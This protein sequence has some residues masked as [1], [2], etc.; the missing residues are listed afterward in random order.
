M[1][2][3]MSNK[4]RKMA[5]LTALIG[6]LMAGSS[7]G[8]ANLMATIPSDYANSQMGGVTGSRVTTKVDAAPVVG[9]VKNLNRDPATFSVMLDGESKIFLRQYVYGVTDLKGSILMD[10]DGD[11]A[12]GANPTGVIKAVPNAHAV[13][14]FGNTIYATGYDQGQVGIAHIVDNQIAEDT[15]KTVDLKKDIKEKTGDIDAKAYDTY[16]DTNGSIQTTTVHG[17]GLLV[18]DGYLYV[19][20]SVNLKGGYDNYDNGYLMQYKINSDGGL[21]YNGYARIGK[22]TDQV[23]LN[24]YNHLIL[25]TSI[26]GYQNYGFGN[27][28][29]SLDYV[30]INGNNIGNL[31]DK[32]S[33]ILPE[34]V[35]NDGYDFRDMKVLPDGTVYVMKYTLS[36]VGGDNK[37][38]FTGRVYQTTMANLMS[39]N[40]DDWNIVLAGTVGE[41][42]GWFGRL[43]AEY[44]T[45][46]L[47]VEWGN[48]LYVY[49][50]GDTKPTHQWETKDFSTD[51]QFYQFNS[52]T[53]LPTDQ[54][55]GSL[56]KLT[57]YRPEGFT[58]SSE[59]KIT[60]EN[61]D[62][63]IG[64]VTRKAGIT[65]TSADQT[66]FSDVI[67]DDGTYSF[68]KDEVL[69]INLGKEGDHAT[70]AAAV[71]QAK[72]GKDITI[73]AS[74]HTLQLASKNYI[75]SPVG[76]YA[77]NGKNVTITADKVDVVTSGYS[78]GNSLT[79]AI[80]NDGGKNTASQ[81]TVNGD[82]NISMSDG[83]GGNGVAI[84]K[85]FRWGENSQESKAS[86]A[87]T[88]HGNLKIAGEDSATWGIPVN[89]E[90][91][92]SRFNNAGILTNIE[93]SKVT[94]TGD[95]DMAV[96]GNGITTN[97]VGSEV[98]IGGGH[99]TVPQGTK[100]G[101]YTLGAYAGTINVNMNKAGSAAG[102]HDVQLD[103]DVFALKSTGTIN[104][105]LATKNSYLHGII[106]NGGKVNMWLQNGAVWT[107][108]AKNTRYKQDDEDV[109]NNEVSRVTYLHGG[110][111][112]GTGDTAGVIIQTANSKSLTIDKFSG[113]AKVL[114]SHDSTTPTKILGGDVNIGSAIRGSEIVLRT[115]YDDN[116]QSDAVKNQVLNALAEK[117]YYKNAVNG[118]TFLS[119]KV[120][121]AEGLT[122]SSV[123][124][125]TG[126]IAFNQTNGQGSFA[127]SGETPEPPAEQ[128]K[129]LF[130]SSMTGGDDKE[131]KDDHVWQDQVYTFTKDKTTVQVEGGAAVDAVK[132][133][134]ITADGNELDL[135]GGE[136]G[137][138]AAAGKTVDITAGT[139]K[140]N[141]RTGIDA[142]GTV[143]LKGKSEITG[144]EKAVN[145]QKG[146]SV[147]LGTSTISGDVENSGHLTLDA[148]TTVSG[149]IANAGVLAVNGETH[150][151]DL[152]TTGTMTVGTDG[153]LAADNINVNGGTFTANGSVSSTVKADKGGKAIL[154]GK[155]TVLK[156]LVSGDHSNIE[157]TLSG[158]DSAL[159]GS[160]D[161]AGSVTLSLADQA[162]WT[163]NA[164]GNGAYAVTVGKDSTWTG[165]SAGNNTS[166]TLGG[167]WNN[168]GTSSLK[169]M[170]GNGGVIDMTD[171]KAGTVTIQNYGGSSTYI[172]KH[173]TTKPADANSGYAILGGDVKISHAD[174]GS[175]I[176]LLTDRT[177]LDF[178]S[179][180]ADGKNLISGTLNALAGKLYY[181][182]YADGNLSGTVKIAEGLTASSASLRSETI[183]FSTADTG[184]KKAGQ[185][186]YDYTP[187]TDEKPHETGPIVKSE[188]ID[189]TR[190]GDV[191]GIVSINVTEAQDSVAS[192]APSAMY[193]AGDAVSPLVVDLQGHTLKLNANNQTANY[194]STVYVDD[195]KSMEIKDSKGNGVLKV[196]AGLDADGNTDTKAKY[197]Y[198][199]RV[200]EGGSLTADT[201]VEIDGVKSNS[202]SRAFGVYAYSE[203][204]V[205]F[206][207]DLT[208]KNVQ[209]ANKVGPYTA[210]I[211][212]DASS[213]AKSPINITVK[214]NL[215]IENV[216]GS[217]IRALNTST[218]STAGATIKAADMS[219]GTDKSQ[220]YA[221]QAN[222]GTINLNTGEGIT[223]GVLDVTGDMKVTDNK[224]SVIN[225]NMT[226]GS[227][228]TGAVSN[229]SSSTYNAPAGQFNLT[230]AEGSAWKHETGRSADTL[231]TTFAGS[232]VSKL[233][234]S[235]VIYQNSDKGITVY[236]YS[237]DTT[238]V[239]GHD[240]S[241]PLII[242]GGD[243]TIKAAA[244][245]SKITLVTDSQGIT[246]GFEAS[247]TAAEKN[248]VKEVLNKLA[249]KLFYT[250]YKDATLFGVVKIADGLT[251]SSVKASGDV[252]FSDGTNGTKKKGQ[253]FYAYTPEQEKPN[254][255]TG[256]ITKSEDISL[257][258]ELDESG[259]AHVSVTESNA[260]GDKFASALYAGESTSPSS[261]M[262]VKMSG[263]GL[264]LNVAQSSGQAAAI[265]AG[266]NTYIKVVNPS[267]DQKLAIT[268]NNTDT[269]GAHGIY[270]DGN[271]HLNISGPVEITDIV[272]KG[273]AATGI[274]IQGKQSEITIDGPL[275]IS[276]VKGL[277]ERGAGMNASGIQVT[278]DSST[279]T[280]SG[281]V[282][283]SGVRGSGIKLAGKDTKV[284]V[285]GGT[286][287]AAEDSDHSHNFY[288][289]RVDK[290]TLDIN[291]KDGAA[292]DTTTKIT[293][294][295]YATG[296]YGKKVVEYTGGELIDWKDAGILNVA[297]TDKDSFW[298]GV[299]AYDQYND[300]YGT[301]GN[302]AHDIGQFN[303]YL[304]NGATWTNE[305]Q[306]HVTTT[307]IASK[308]P[309]W[310]GST[311]ATLHGGKDADHAGL[312]YQKDNNPIS[313]VN[314]SG[315][316]TVFYEHD[317]ADPTKII[318]GNF[319][320]TNAAEGSAIT[321]IT[322]N[323]GIT[324][325]FAD[326]DSA[327][328][329]DKVANVLNNLAGKLFY[330]N[331]TD[332]HLSGVVKIA[333]G[334]TASSRALKTGD[335]S[336]STDATGTKTPGQ[337]Y[338]EYKTSKPGSQT[339]KEFTAAIT[340]D[341]SVDTAYADKGVL[342]D[343]GTYVFTA[344]S[345]TIT[346]E[347]HLI[348]GGPWLPQIS[349]AISGS[350]EKH[351]VTMDMNGN[352]L[353][354]DT[355]TDTHTTGIAAIGKGVV[356]IK[357][358]GAMSVS[359]TSTK[360]GQIGALFVNGGGTIQI[361]NAG[362]DNVLTLRAKST[363]PANAAVIKSMNGVSG[364]M[365]SI[366]VDGLVDILA[367]K[368]GGSGANEAISAV[369]SKVEVGG[370]V[371]KA[372]NG[373]EYAIRAYGEFNSKNRGQVN[374]NVK[375]DAKGAVIGAGSNTVQLEG[376]VYLG[377][378]M[379]NAGASAD[380]SLGLNTKDSF[381][382]GDV[383][384]ANGSNA[385]IVNLYMGSGASWTGN[386]LSGNT[387]NADLDNATWTGYSSGNA[388]H[389][390]LDNSIW[391]VNGASKIA[392]FSGNKGS[393]FV[394]SDAGNISVGDYSGNT[395]VIYNH[396]ADHPTN[397]LGGNF[398]IGQA[399]TGSHITLITDNQGITKGFTAQDKAEDQ[400]TVNEVL[401]KLAQKLFYTANDGKLA[402]TVKIAE[403]LTAS[404]KALK[405]G[406]ISFSTDATGTKTPGQGFYEYTA[407]DDS[408]ITDPIT[409][410]LD[411]KY[412]NLGIETEKGIY[413]FTQDTV[414]DV[415]KGDYSS[416]LSAIESSGGPITINA[417]GKNLDV[418]YHVLKGSNVARAVATGLRT[419]IKDVTI[420]AKSL[421]LSTD[422][423][424]FRAQGVYAT[425]GKI[426]IDADTT[427]ST[428]AQTESN[429]IYSGNGGTV[430]MS[431]NLTIQKDSKAANYIALKSDDN[432]VINVN[433]K[434]GKVGAGIVKI[435]GDVY[436]KS[437]ETYD[438]WEDETTSTSS[439]VNLALQGKDS[440]WNGRSLYEVTSGDDST[441]YGTFNLWL[442]DGATWTNEK[443]G[444][445]VPSGFT[446]SHVTK[447]TG[448][449]DAAHAGNIFQNDTKKITIDNYSGNTNIYYAHTGNG[450]AASDYA[451]G[452]T[453]IK[454]AEKDS[455]V[456]LITDN[457]G[458]NMNSADS[459]VNVLNSLAGKL[460]YSNFTKNENNLTGYVKIADG[461][462]SSSA[463][464]YTGDM[465]FSKKDGKGSLK[466]ED[467]IRPDLPAPDH[468]IKNEF[469]TT[470]TGVKSKDKEYYKA[471]VI[472][473]EGLYQ[474]TQNSSITT[475]N[476]HG[477]DMNQATTIDAKGKTLTFN[478]DLTYG[479]TVHAIGAN[480]TDGVTINAGKLVL[481][482]HSTNGRIEGINVGQGALTIN[483]NTEMNIKGVGYT[484]GLYAAGDSALTFNG[485][486]TAMGDETS[487]WGLT[488]KN[489][490]WGYY[491]CS[492]VYSD[493]NYG[494]QKGPKVTINGDVNAKIDG[495][496]LFAKGGHAKLTINGGGNIEINKDNEHTYYAMIAECGTTSM[497]VNLDENYDAVS[498]RDNKLV[499]KG[500]ISASTG[501]ISAHETE[502]YTKVNLGLATADSVW[503]GVAHNRF[504]DDGNSAYSSDKKFYGAINVFLQNGATWN[505]EKW[506]A[507]YKPWGSSGFAGSHVA[508][509]VGGSDVAHAGNIFQKDA[510]SLT[511]DNYSGNT[512]IFYAHTGNGEAADNYAAGDTVIKHAAEGSVVS[513]ITDNTGVAMDNEYSVAN[514]LNALAGKL[515]YSNFVTGE[516]NLTG[517]VKIAEGLTASSAAMQTGN[518]A[519]NA[520]TGK[521]SLENGS[522]KPGFTYPE[523]QKPEAT[524]KNQGITGDAKTD[525]QYKKDGILKEDGSY[526]F[527][528]NPTKIEV[529]SGAAV[530]ATENNINIDS[531]QAKLELKG[532]T[533]I[534]AN[535]ADVTVNGNTSISGKVGID[536]ANGNVTL[537]GS[538]DIVGTDA[539]INAGEGGNVDINTNNSA[540]N[541]KGDINADGGSIIVA[542]GKATGVIAGDVSASNG[543]SVEISLNDAKSSL[544]GSYR[545]DDSSSIV[546][547]I[548]NGAT[549]N[550]TDDEDDAEGMSLFRMAKAPAAAPAAGLNV[551]GGAT[552]AETGYIDMTK[553]TQKLDIANFSGWETIIYGHEN[554]GDKDE[555][556]KSGNT[557]INKAAKDSG[558]ILSTDNSGI[559]MDDKAAVEATLKALAHKLTYTD[560]EENGSNLTG[561]VQIADGLTASS[562]SK[563][564]GNMRWDEN[565]KGQYVDGSIQW[566]PTIEK[567]EYETFVMKGAR[568]AVTTSFHSWRDNMQDT[569]TGADLADEDGIFAKALGGKTSSDVSGL[570]DS[571]SY[572]GAQVG[573]D[574]ALAN[575]WHTGVAFDY[576]DGDS[577]YLLGGKGDNKLYS[578]GV[579]GVKKMEDGSYF[580][581]AAKAGRVEN[582]YD[583]YTELRNKLHADYK[584][585]AYGLTAE[586]GKTFGSEMSYI[587][588][589]VQL[590]WS[591]VGSKDY[592]GSANNGATMNIYQDS[593]DSLVG[594][595]GFEAGMKKAHGS[596]HAGLYLAHEFN[597]DIDT[598]YFAK[599][600]GWKSTSFDGDDTWAELVLG[601]EYRLGGNSQL[602]A[603]FARDLGG[604]FQRK[605]K[606]NAGIRL[607]F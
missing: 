392:S 545:V 57:T 136:A 137:I 22:N 276:N 376:N 520:D 234:G 472:K 148:V 511:I 28:E 568:S 8:A 290:G 93:K 395:T 310:E 502:L 453:I 526:V 420:K 479:T 153:V 404:S 295:M 536:A 424:G 402:G 64:T 194:V 185:G 521:G 278:G 100:Y 324:S 371:I 265:Y 33:I 543:G 241:D 114:Y 495:N 597:G 329:K 230:M 465:A 208:I 181:T 243:F 277:K 233:D 68:T 510:N 383:S 360:G 75:A 398:T 35:K 477:A 539:A 38:G 343:D 317:A 96:Y 9:A 468:Q 247:D 525:Y 29:T 542:S 567:G 339:A 92:L 99:I 501:A 128:S 373:A 212:A 84:Q 139:L 280:V 537:N 51:K 529:E 88:I 174:K 196:S 160:L 345:T 211:Y 37:S 391:N 492:L 490:A 366:T 334:L 31:H 44:Y 285:G 190:V 203:G 146:G 506:G 186:F 581:V 59:T 497:N 311:L 85:S 45:K 47:W 407:K 370:G 157:A 72:D 178:A 533:G 175:E 550:L 254:Y 385:G 275:T 294:D 81:I 120:E 426:T 123:A 603:D 232:N 65:G 421:K 138:R 433:M 574:K 569:Y 480:S 443:N 264:A 422:T 513:M 135:T 551:N 281:P 1:M 595:L 356:N 459:I 246:G 193:V 505:N 463:A 309:V 473:G 150:A 144:T 262:T 600:G 107:N 110:T 205:V 76:I 503:T 122:A 478:T 558:V 303:L 423:T 384:N 378:G 557:I 363:A 164:D 86:S 151:K 516:K 11:W 313:V 430:T 42:G 188:N 301:G 238:V 555:D 250:G 315:H 602:Y 541:I 13:T 435:D 95:V 445:E 170:A 240:A 18:K 585:N 104:L 467:S 396:D 566:E 400:N 446:G 386:N 134:T 335:I 349:A 457:S 344:D 412:E 60:L 405:T 554:A 594:R 601:G 79:N 394:A 293:G 26:G 450:E 469:T 389:L 249:N 251:A 222:K 4:K 606:L 307:T 544:T 380:V 195:N 228:W 564:L 74:G 102:T 61:A 259:V 218:I 361:H 229:I 260:G 348:A 48:N 163:G 145:V 30:N 582:E 143:T 560:H 355:T 341:A 5:F 326:D 284:S 161:G 214:G 419:G 591:R 532:E 70:N 183:T 49:E 599:D 24:N 306:S 496:C 27:K 125:Y 126:N 105:R 142:A 354:V 117:L 200:G 227:Q 206:E 56:A 116:M 481:N 223:A 470:L 304:Q 586:Y 147:T 346:P 20:A 283:I 54:V 369:A 282:D 508:K 245:G 66:A 67:S 109:G 297:L 410:N 447:L 428:S 189:E 46:R 337:G 274:N 172:Y 292:G 237:G 333:E 442:T 531:T 171:A 331:Y 115:D 548:A 498:A 55:W 287:T 226:K 269:R 578:F 576:R 323:K 291:M 207:K 158:K 527:T 530:D 440:S 312:I 518:I 182:G 408:V 328:A 393:I 476:A 486:V 507:T 489:G 141:G 458:V 519:F 418:S 399:N 330:K 314:Y 540:L 593:Y 213:S 475:T 575:G 288:A 17:E 504:N 239:Y 487:E 570:K 583:V 474:F 23:K 406:N 131:Y 300:N 549:W 316:T 199:I 279:V 517:Y 322:D 438:Y 483:G 220:Y 43:N 351:N 417:D 444:K 255:K 305:Q 403:G 215:N 482:A 242:N 379:D 169:Q 219:N 133:V 556:Y 409:G 191:N 522:M 50:D 415:T 579:Y 119:G 221:L 165:S 87:I 588:P 82:V 130:T 6:S 357:N 320:I 12:S 491:R 359:A 332:G 258:R 429:G 62:A 523:T 471:G 598:R 103:G 187:A 217:A 387:V 347:K 565:G 372:I 210:G 83:Y 302:T 3:K 298:K 572:W 132:D 571:N 129:T 256:A 365:S 77:G 436:T 184:T 563:Y 25:S 455:V 318:G 449:S 374:V 464:M 166:L 375:K 253:G 460:T 19:A 584:A 461:L 271:A 299:A 524:E 261:P 499:L 441:S 272:T 10:A 607:R 416:N 577:D 127:G 377:G 177:G 252:T 89:Q 336:F 266:A 236:N 401:N 108:E 69:S 71:I 121:I 257:S 273:D 535:G 244:A 289:V 485:N 340:G 362:A 552:K 90:N 14:G 80:W 327:D 381:W 41:D 36:D 528:Q 382:K 413:N 432:G 590:T 124:K 39:K 452:D 73:D 589:K 509:F 411:K 451:A 201:D 140:V 547:N 437:A 202:S 155:K 493:S 388:M 198:G 168:R 512:N 321:F 91:V 605:W 192:S 546:M 604:D 596:L 40:P 466:D 514:V 350:D 454:H 7:V 216:L 112:S 325:G 338:Y 52:V 494:L 98:S 106:D 462:T 162:N 32:K 364:V 562:A 308:N 2:W 113:A 118:E 97:A 156:G 63:K 358:A 21:S 53:M 367:E 111:K 173:D 573:Y 296:Q 427:I 167:T 439:T 176:T 559:N 179:T 16:T 268:A 456:S 58:A 434:D 94:V 448:G 267:A 15:T 500:N 270:A 34:Q 263:K 197:V 235:G 580:R 225:V 154:K 561:K 431:G 204:N 414:I 368:S 425:G 78:S 390:K 224:A 592:T 286:I 231:N 248:H 397:I 149:S 152:T 180:K 515:T 352:K 319:N 488:A 538:T 209:T 553:R 353:T 484:L 534:H 342:K 587:T 101:Y 159:N